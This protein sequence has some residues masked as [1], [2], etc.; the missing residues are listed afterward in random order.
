MNKKTKT[1]GASPLRKVLVF[2][3]IFLLAFAVGASL[4]RI[5]S[6][7]SEGV[8]EDPGPSIAEGEQVNILIMG[9]DARPKEKNSRTDTMILACI[10]PTAH[11]AALLSIPRDTRADV[12]GSNINKINDAHAIGGPEAAC[13]AVEKLLDVKVDYYVVTNFNGFANIIDILGGVTIDVEK[14]MYRPTEDINLHAGVQHLDGSDALAY[15]RFRGD[16]LGDIAR[17]QRQQKFIRALA[18][19]M[20]QAKT[21]WKIPALIPEIKD[22][23]ETDMGTKTMMELAQLGLKFTADD[24]TAQTLPGYFYDDPDTGASYWVM[25]ETKAHDLIATMLAG[26]E[27][28]VVEES[29]YR[30]NTPEKK[31]TSVDTS[32]DET[33]EVPAEEAAV[34]EPTDLPSDIPGDDGGSTDPAAPVE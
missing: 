4:P 17:T 25:D 32:T 9:I 24:I 14:R 34:D 23:V 18:E 15:V 16:A 19:E 22:N 5:V 29:P 31:N 30:A 3:I 12:P 11:K 8:K 33:V 26:Q 2:I 1:N 6:L 13:T 28:Q 21:I 27:V 20:M 7:V 10:D